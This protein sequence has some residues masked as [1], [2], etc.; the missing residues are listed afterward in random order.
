MGTGRVRVGIFY[1][2]TRPV[3]RLLNGFFSEPRLGQPN[4]GQSVAQPKKKKK[5]KPK[6][7][8]KMAKYHI[9][10]KILAKKHC[11]GNIWQSPLFL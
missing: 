1:T 6:Q 4:L 2:W 5:M 3:A 9:F 11:F 8:A 7:R 10:W